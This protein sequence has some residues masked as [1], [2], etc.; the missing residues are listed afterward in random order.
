[1]RLKSLYV[2]MFAV[3]AGIL[4]LSFVVFHEIS[5]RMQKQTIDPTFERADELELESARGV[6]ESRA[7][8]HCAII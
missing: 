6:Y 2:G 7:R 4:A 8:K 1:M 3:I 5:A